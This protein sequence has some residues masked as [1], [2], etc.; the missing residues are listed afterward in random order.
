MIGGTIR[1]G[2]AEG[3][4]RMSRLGAGIILWL[5]VGSVWGADGESG[6]RCTTDRQIIDILA[7]V[8]DQGAALFNAGDPAGCYRMFQG[9]L[10]TVQIVL[11]K[12][13]QDSVQRGLARAELLG[14]PIRR[15]MALHELIEEVR[16]QLH[17]STQ[18]SEALPKPRP[19][20]AKPS[21][22]EKAP[23]HQRATPP[24]GTPAPLPTH[25]KTPEP[26][27]IPEANPPRSGL[28]APGPDF[29]TPEPPKAPPAPDRSV[30]P[31]PPVV[32]GIPKAQPRPKGSADGDN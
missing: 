23:E 20:P 28:Q 22:A 16:R 25:P 19:A 8:H 9:A 14:D 30:S 11:P 1:F 27:K 15:A 17:P 3:D 18:P 5:A 10:V 7:R 12:E 6:S 2:G 24:P 4:R 29:S 26:L 31:P 13:L 32:S 21:G